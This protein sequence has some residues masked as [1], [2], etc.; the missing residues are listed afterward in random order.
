MPT[1]TYTSNGTFS[2]ATTA[3]VTM[4][5]W[6]AGGDGNANGTGGSGGAYSFKM[7][8]LQSGS[9][10]IVVGQRNSDGG[11]NGGS[12]YITSASVIIARAA[13]GKSDGTISHQAVLNTGSIKCVEVARTRV[14]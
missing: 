14:V 5:L 13:G 11:G 8:N 12:S 4:S 6:G 10:P 7:V 3:K 1:V 9:Y 2:T